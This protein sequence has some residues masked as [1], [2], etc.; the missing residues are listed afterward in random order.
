MGLNDKKNSEL[1]F[2]ANPFNTLVSNTAVKIT[3]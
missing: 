3:I 2:S 1:D